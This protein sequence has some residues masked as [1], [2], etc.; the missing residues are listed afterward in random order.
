MTDWQKVA[1]PRGDEP[2]WAAARSTECEMA[3]GSAARLD[4]EG[5]PHSPSSRAAAIA[6]GVKFRMTF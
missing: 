3:Q 1:A 6:L 4:N 5:H 2:G